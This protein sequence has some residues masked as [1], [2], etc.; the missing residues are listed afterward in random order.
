MF[1][2]LEKKKAKHVK[3]Y[4]KTKKQAKQQQNS[5]AH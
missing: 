3:F 4:T 5:I 1:S 2:A